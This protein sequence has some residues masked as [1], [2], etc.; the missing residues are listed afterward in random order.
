MVTLSTDAQINLTVNSDGSLTANL[1]YGGIG[2]TNSLQIYIEAPQSS[3]GVNAEMDYTLGIGGVISSI[4]LTNTG[5][6]YTQTPTLLL[7]RNQNT[8]NPLAF[9]NDVNDLQN[10]IDASLNILSTLVQGALQTNAQSDLNMNNNNIS[11]V[12]QIN[13]QIYPFTPNLSQV[14]SQGNQCSVNLDLYGSSIIDSD[15]NQVNFGNNI[16]LNNTKITTDGHIVSSQC[17]VFDGFDAGAGSVRFRADNNAGDYNNYTEIMSFYNNSINAYV[18]FYMNSNQIKNISDPTDNQDC[19]TKN[20]VDKN[21]SGASLSNNNTFTG[22]NTFTSN[23]TST[24]VSYINTA[25]RNDYF[26]YNPF[27]VG[28]LNTYLNGVSPQGTIRYTTGDIGTL[29]GYQFQNITYASYSIVA[30]TIWSPSKSFTLQQNDYINFMAN[31]I[32]T[33]YTFNINYQFGIYDSSGSTL[34]T[35]TS[36]QTLSI[37]GTSSNPV[38]TNGGFLL[39]NQHTGGN[40]TFTQGNNYYVAFYIY[41]DNNSQT[42]PLNFLGYALGAYLNNIYS[43]PTV[44]QLNNFTSQPYRSL[45]YRG[46]GQNKVFTQLPSPFPFTSIKSSGGTSIIAPLTQAFGTWFCITSS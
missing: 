21:S 3:S 13:G 31:T 16:V 9:I 7:V 43:T 45:W 30:M 39:K 5:S 8:P 25:D 1:L 12:N 4:N 34:L 44:S 40:V 24:G 33:T 26:V 35:T 14:M 2:Y 46:G 28:N 32:N 19:A 22:N 38:N 42:C 23:L 27:S 17:L 18:P 29:F 15:I 36:P 20:Y 10:S 6:G 37:S 41:S 11:N